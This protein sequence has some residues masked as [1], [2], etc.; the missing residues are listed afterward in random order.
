MKVL[1]KSSPLLIPTY[2]F[3]NF[4][5]YLNSLSKS[6]RY[7][8]KKNLSLNV[9][10][11]YSPVFF[12]YKECKKFMDI[13]SECNNWSWGDWYSESELYNLH[14]RGILKCFKC[15]DLAYHFV[16]KW[17]RYIYC[18]APLYN[19]NL[20][21]NSGIAKWMWLK[22]I[23][24]C[25]NNKDTDYIDLMGPEG[26]DTFGEV[27]SN[28]HHTDQSGDFGYKW[29]F[30]PEDIKNQKI[31]IFNDL[32][33]L[34]DKKFIWKNTGLPVRPNKLLI[35]AHPDDEAIFFGDWLLKNAKETKVVCLT[36]STNKVRFK[37]FQNSMKAAGVFY[38]ECL[39]IKPSLSLFKSIKFIT[40]TLARINQETDWQQIV[41]HNL[42][43]EYG[44]LQHIHTHEIVK[45]IFDNN[46]IFVYTNSNKIL[47]NKNKDILLKE[48]PSQEKFCI[49]EIRESLCTGS[50]WYK[51]TI[52][53]NMID[54]ESITPLN[55]SKNNLSIILHWTKCLDHPTCDFIRALTEQ[56][57]I[58][59]HNCY[60][61]HDK[62]CITFTQ[63][64][65]IRIVFCL[66]DAL[67]CERHS[68]EFFFFIN[69]EVLHLKQNYDDYKRII[70]KSIRSFVQTRKTR[71]ELGDKMN[72]I[73]LPTQR[74]WNIVTRKIEAHLYMGLISQDKI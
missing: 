59:G 25:I 23:E 73:W 11:D 65:D 38:Y 42:Y 43:G 1:E 36:E 68:K 35:V 9:D 10:L 69:E 64:P 57:S 2:I 71:D 53:K 32:K 55:K 40:E 51:H 30:I 7:D 72:L 12:N 20:Q 33:I 54:Y 3:N 46:K 14:D 67:I 6:S 16:L 13:W 48:Y 28:R 70:E 29:K 74:K 17:N 41:T 45:K 52:G 61:S 62:N 22:L 15:N 21:P 66:E 18:N 37:E 60:L 58:R 24:H 50:D 31:K 4:E 63:K 56:L 8:L 44:H 19:K 5:E 27:I 47:Q 34:S 26:L 49:N 39:P